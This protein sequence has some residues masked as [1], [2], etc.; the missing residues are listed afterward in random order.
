MSDPK[1]FDLTTCPHW[2]KGGR[3]VLD[4]STGKRVRVDPASAA[5]IDPVAVAGDQAGD[6]AAGDS[7]NTNPSKGKRNG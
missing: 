4:P 2:G 7:A 5:A 3:Y 1:A 6:Q